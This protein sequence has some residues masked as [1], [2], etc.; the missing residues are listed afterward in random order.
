MVKNLGDGKPQIRKTSH[1]CLLAYVKTYKTFDEVIQ[2]YIHYGIHSESWQLRQKS[3]N[4]FQS[5]LIMEMK[6]LNWSSAEFRKVVEELL[7]RT[8]DENQY[9]QKAS[10]QCLLSI[11][12]YEELRNFSKKLPNAFYNSLK[13]FC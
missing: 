13:Q 12:K 11:C 9:V 5:I 3:I 8:N 6:Y 2:I 1:Y 4:S 7:N 10:E